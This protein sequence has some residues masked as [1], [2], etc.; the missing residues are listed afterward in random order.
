MAFPL[1]RYMR[2]LIMKKYVFKGLLI[3]SRFSQC[4]RRCLFVATAGG[5]L[6]FFFV[7]DGGARGLTK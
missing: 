5:A 7:V 1:S 2:G 4:K 3:Q 6:F